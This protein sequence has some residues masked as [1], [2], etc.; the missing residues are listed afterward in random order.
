MGK[1]G[2]AVNRELRLRRRLL[3]EAEASQGEIHRQR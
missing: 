3:A 1:R 2:T